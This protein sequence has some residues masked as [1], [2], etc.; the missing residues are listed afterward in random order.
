MEALENGRQSHR[1]GRLHRS[2]S[3][4]AADRVV[5]AQF[6]PQFVVERVEAPC[7]GQEAFA[8]RRREHASAVPDEQLDAQFGLELLDAR[9]HVGLHGVQLLRGSADRAASR[10]GDEGFQ[11]DRVHAWGIEK[12]DT[13][14]L[15]VSFPLTAR[16]I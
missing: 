15:N 7:K 16:P 6:R 14:D 10:H 5:V 4:M 8:R 1:P 12:G 2:E 9:G 13:C 11:C 3:E